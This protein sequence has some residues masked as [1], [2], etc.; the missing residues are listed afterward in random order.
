MTTQAMLELILRH[1]ITF[2]FGENGFADLAQKLDLL[3]D[4]AS[5]GRVD[6]LTGLPVEVVRGW[7]CEIIFIAQETLVELDGG[8]GDAI[9]N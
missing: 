4:A 6:M 7:L 3:H 9:W 2:D 1:Q 8:Q 5:F